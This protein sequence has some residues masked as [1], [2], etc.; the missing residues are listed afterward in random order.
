MSSLLRRR[1]PER[2]GSNRGTIHDHVN[3]MISWPRHPGGVN[4]ECEP[5][6]PAHAGDAKGDVRRAPVAPRW[7]LP[8]GDGCLHRP[9]L[10]RAR[11][12]TRAVGIGGNVGC[13]LEHQPRIERHGLGHSLPHPGICR[14]KGLEGNSG[15]L[16]DR[17]DRCRRSPTRRQGSRVQSVQRRASPMMKRRLTMTTSVS[18]PVVRATPEHGCGCRRVSCGLFRSA[19]PSDPPAA[20]R[21]VSHQGRRDIDHHIPS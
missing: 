17:T 2:A 16:N 10:C 3:G 18:I 20:S 6:H 8:D 14:R 19:C 9:L 5:R 13:V 12:M 1:N 4:G 21:R 7:S 11:A 15:A